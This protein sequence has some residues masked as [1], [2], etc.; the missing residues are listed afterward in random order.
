MSDPDEVN[1]ATDPPMS[2]LIR[3]GSIARHA[4]ELF[5][6]DPHEVDKAAIESLLADPDVKAWMAAADEMALLP[7]KR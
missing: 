4:E 7:V 1:L 5:G 2:T 3:L 6:D